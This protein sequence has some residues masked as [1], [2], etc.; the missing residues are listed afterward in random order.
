MYNDNNNDIINDYDLSL[1]FL[2]IVN[3]DMLI[4]I[5]LYATAMYLWPFQPFAF[6]LDAS[7]TIVL[8]QYYS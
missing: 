4:T 3:Q 8:G 2:D 5:I 6:I 1:L 7:Q